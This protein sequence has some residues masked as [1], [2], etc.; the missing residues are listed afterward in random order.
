M[1][2]R[3]LLTPQDF[4]GR[5]AGTKP[6]GNRSASHFHNSIPG[7]R[8][9]CWKSVNRDTLFGPGGDKNG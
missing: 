6:A 2:H 5:I 3:S 1:L 9:E 7:D 4:V 8:A